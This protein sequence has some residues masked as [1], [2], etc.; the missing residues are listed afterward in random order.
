MPNRWLPVVGG[1]LMNLALG[2]LYAWSVF[3][4]PLER[5]FGWRRADT[6][7]VYTIA[8]VTFALTFVAAGRIQDLKGPK[9]CA[10]L[11]GLLVSGG[12]FLSSYTSSLLFLY[13]T[14]G[15]VVGLGNGFGYAT[16][17]PVASKWFPDKRG[18]VVGLMVGGYGAG[19]ALLGPLAIRLISSV[20]W[21]P[22]FQILGVVFFVMTMIGTA[23]LKNPPAGY[24]PPNWQPPV[25]ILGSVDSSTAEMLATPTFYLMWVAYCLGTTA[26]QM[27]ISQLVPFAGSAGLGALAAT[28]VLPVS[29]LGNAGGRI[30]SGWM[31]DRFGRLP[32]LKTMILISAVAMPALVLWRQQPALFF[33]LVA[34]V[35]WCYGTQLSVF[36]STTA[37]F[38]GTRNLGLN[39]GVLFTAWGAAGI[40]GPA[41][42]GR[43]FDRFGD[44][45]VAFFSA[46]VLA[47]V[48]LASLAAARAPTKPDQVVRA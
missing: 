15:V 42:A 18:F 43:A 6:S 32:T 4:L 35:Y 14:F 20:G 48:A 38:Y 8:I 3:V 47:L 24:R 22:T 31:S 34:V 9:I 23:L 12:F 27:A 28:L 13:V 5:E 37:D 16:P 19:S 7:W 25:G 26:G 29:A 44:Y 36:A 11:G 21:R 33:I 30:L 41:I 1:I 17:I 46:G 10:F 40:L 45:R 2:S 39:Y